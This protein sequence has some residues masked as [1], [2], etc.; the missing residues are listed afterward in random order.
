[1]FF[2]LLWAYP[3]IFGIQSKTEKSDRKPSV[4]AKPKGLITHSFLFLFATHNDKGKK[5]EKEPLEERENA[6]REK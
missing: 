4:R 6:L 1:V 5:N 2:F 3:H